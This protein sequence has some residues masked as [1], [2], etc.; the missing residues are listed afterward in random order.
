M[1]TANVRIP[2][3]NGKDVRIFLYNKMQTDSLCHSVQLDILQ[4]AKRKLEEGGYMDK[5]S[6]EGLTSDGKKRKLDE[7]KA[8][9]NKEKAKLTRMV[10][11]EYMK[12]LESAI[13]QR[14]SEY[15]RELESIPLSTI[16]LSKNSE[17]NYAANLKTNCGKV[18]D[19]DQESKLKLSTVDGQVDFLG[20]HAKFKHSEGDEKKK[21]GKIL[22]RFLRQKGMQGMSPTGLRNTVC[23]RHENRTDQR[24]SFAEERMGTLRS[25]IKNS[26]DK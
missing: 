26:A 7:A 12:R 18:A 19:I 23:Q 14:Q 15:S 2:A 1:K 11:E 10:H 6:Y 16:P 20:E 9:C 3:N 4:N 22:L 8:I 13:P 17:E 5:E 24:Q 25:L 21:G